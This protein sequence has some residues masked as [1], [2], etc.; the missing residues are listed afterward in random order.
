[1]ERREA[2]DAR[3]VAVRHRGCVV[4]FARKQWDLRDHRVLRR[5][6]VFARERHQDRAGADRSIEALGKPLLSADLEAGK[7][8]AERLVE[9]LAG[10][11]GRNSVSVI[12][13]LIRRRDERIRIL[14]HAVRIEERAAEIDHAVAAP[15]HL[16]PRL[17]RDDRDN[18]RVEVLLLRGR[19]ERVDILRV[20][21]DGHALL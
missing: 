18:L 15:L 10:E 11:A 19:A 16:E 8:F 20:E 13:R 2:R 17:R 14:R 5:E 4:G 7:V 6:L 3:D 1:M 12:F 21:H 9:R